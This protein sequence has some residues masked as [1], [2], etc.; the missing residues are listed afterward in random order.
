MRIFTATE[1]ASGDRGVYYVDR[2][3]ATL[4][5]SV[6]ITREDNQLNGEYAEIDMKAGISRLLPGPPGS[7]STARVRGLLM[8]KRKPKTDQG[9]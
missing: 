9:S 8:P 4:T 3:F 2:E 1:F 5:G 7:T 6:K